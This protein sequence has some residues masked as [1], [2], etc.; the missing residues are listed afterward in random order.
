MA[1]TVLDSSKWRRA[2]QAEA[3]RRADGTRAAV[4]AG[5][6]RAVLERMRPGLPLPEVA[7]PFPLEVHHAISS[8]AEG[9]P[10]L[11]A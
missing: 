11:P 8:P 4:Q 1:A 7:D 6:G 9:L 5:Q 2:Y 10:V 3:R